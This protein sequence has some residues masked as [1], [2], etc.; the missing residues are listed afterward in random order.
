ML[1]GTCNANEGQQGDVVD[2]KGLHQLVEFQIAGG[3]S[4]LLA[5]GTTGESPTLTWDEHSEVIV[6]V[7]GFSRGR[8]AVIAGTGSN[9][10]RET[11]EST[12]HVAKHG[13]EV[14]LLVEPYY[15]GPSSLEIRKEYLEPIA[16]QFPD[17]QVIPYVIPGRTGTQLL[18]EDLAI[19]HSE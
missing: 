7:K 11:M 3:V 10:T 16:R 15:N 8:C 17:V 4:G 1:H 9:C 14:I 6:K 18:P 12:R 19:L 2:Y 13:I 5:M